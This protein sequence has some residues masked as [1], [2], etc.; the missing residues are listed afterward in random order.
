MNLYEDHDHR[1]FVDVNADHEPEFEPGGPA[2]AVPDSDPK[3]A[4]TRYEIDGRRIEI[5]DLLDAGLIEPG[6]SLTWERPRLGVKYHATVTDTG[7]IV[8]SDGRTFSSP[9]R[10]AVE[11]A[12]IPA[13]DGWYAWR[14]EDGQRLLD[15]RAKLIEMHSI[16]DP[17]QEVDGVLDAGNAA[18][19]NS[20]SFG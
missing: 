15:L 14:T 5:S 11:A 7:A 19:E 16:E 17:G 8:L 9:S 12:E 4:P 2:S 3:P 10:A 13:F 6:G 1:R 18:A 20:T